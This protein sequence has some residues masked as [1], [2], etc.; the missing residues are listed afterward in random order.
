M[1]SEEQ[2]LGMVRLARTVGIVIL[3]VALFLATGCKGNKP[4]QMRTPAVEA[5]C[6]A[7]CYTPC[8]GK[9][10]DTGVRWEG[11]PNRSDTIDALDNS[12]VIQLA[13]KL[14][15]CD[16]NRKACVKCLDSLEQQKVIIQ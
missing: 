13:K 16:I 11:D 5:K 4:D 7:L 14:R 9:D 10:G 15:S 3:L 1:M 12:V 6:D 8:V 2:Y